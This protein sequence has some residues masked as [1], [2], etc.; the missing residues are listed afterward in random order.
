MQKYLLNGKLSSVDT[1][2]DKENEGDSR[3]TDLPIPEESAIPK[4]PQ[5]GI[6]FQN[7]ESNN[8][9]EDESFTQIPVKEAGSRS[10]HNLKMP[11][12]KA[13]E[14]IANLFKTIENS[15]LQMM[16]KIRVYIVFILIPF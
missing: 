4:L 15:N 7:N 13:D 10:F 11:I 12:L 6:D 1:I 9:H 5:Y 2:I 3:K 16:H 8:L 14:G